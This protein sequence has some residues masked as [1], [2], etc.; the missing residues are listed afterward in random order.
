ME[1][2]YVYTKKCC[3]FGHPC[4]FS[5]SA[6]LHVDIPPNPSLEANFI[7]E[8]L[9]IVGTQCSQKMSEHEVNTNSMESVSQGINHVEG[10]WPKSVNAEN[11]DVTN[12]Y[13]KKVE[14]DEHYQNSIQ[15]LASLIDHCIKQNNATDIYQE[16][17]EDEEVVE[18][19]EEQQTAKFINVFRDPNKVKRT[20]TCLSW[21]PNSNHKLAVAYSCL[22]FQR[23]PKDMSFDSY[24]WDIENPCKPEMT[25]KPVSPL[26]CLEYNPKDSHILVGG[27]YNG[28]IVYWDTRSG[29]HPVEMSAIEHS[30]RNPV[31]KVIWLH[32]TG[33]TFSAST[34][35]QVLWWD[36]RKMSEPID[37]LVLDPNKKGNLED[38]L[39]AIS[40]DFETTMPTKFMVGTEQGLVV[41][42][43]LKAQTPADK[44]ACTYSS[45]HGP[46]YA[47]QR[48]PF[49]P[50]CFLTV[51][52]WTARI[53]SEDIKGSSIMS[54]KY[55]KSS[56]LDGCWSPVRPSVFFTVKMDGTLDAWDLLLKQKNPTLSL[57]VCYEALY[58]I[59]VQDKGRFLG[60]GSRLGTVT[61]LEMTPGL[62]TL[63]RNEKGLVSELFER[64]T[65]RGK[66]LESK[67][68]EMFLKERSLSEQSKEVGGKLGDEEE[69]EEEL[70]ALAEREFFEIVE[71]CKGKDEENK[72]EK[73]E[74]RGC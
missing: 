73:V 19:T 70:L 28:Q 8:D 6:V 61:M 39:G 51:A 11:L 2:M 23:A 37:R 15:H 65:K 49:Y 5:E 4:N 63:Q 32:S 48:N 13:K 34:D 16:Y 53:W 38:A 68:R 74:D 22:E 18:E 21:H 67:Q 42:C 43:N 47:L 62:C 66:I 24:I 3:E 69:S 27:S 50:K 64:E 25:L 57:K 29:S 54:T 17:F 14:K 45:H 71:S 41:T 7:E 20:A 55:H 59:R 31:Y 60:C 36:I 26:V 12:R 1:I 33:D 58:S 52:D 56:L 40:M 72:R 10:G 46:I 30:H 35:G 44:I 9:C